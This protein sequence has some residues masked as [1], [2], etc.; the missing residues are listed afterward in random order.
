MRTDLT[1]PGRPT[2]TG[3][4]GI[5]A[6]DECERLLAEG[7]VG[8]LAI[9]IGGRPRIYPMNYRYEPGLLILRTAPGSKLAGL[10]IGTPW[11]SR[12]TVSTATT[13]QDGAWSSRERLRSSRPPRWLTT[14]VGA[15]YAPGRVASV[16]SGCGYRP[17]PS[18]AASSPDH[19]ERRAQLATGT[20]I[21]VAARILCAISPRRRVPDVRA[22]RL[23]SAAS[24]AAPTKPRGTSYSPLSTSET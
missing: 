1:R 14:Y 13:G 12:S 22:A 9:I 19:R 18:L 23:R 20:S 17:R 4:L 8:R 3:G 16:T 24:M 7:Y 15:H 6:M 11:P 5:L 21:A 10:A 2:D